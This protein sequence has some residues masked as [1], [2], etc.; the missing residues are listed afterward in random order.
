MINTSLENKRIDLEGIK[1][2]EL[3]D[4]KVSL[5]DVRETE[6]TSKRV[7]LEDRRDVS[8]SD[9]ILNL[10]KPG[11]IELGDKNYQTGVYYMDIVNEL[12][13]MGDFIIN[14]SQALDK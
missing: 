6:L 14:I 8:L 12:E 10:K 11:E 13:K 2:V 3:G 9:K 5:K 7:D 4:K 1:D